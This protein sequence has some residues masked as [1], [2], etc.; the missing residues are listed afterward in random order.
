M[1]FFLLTLPILVFGFAAQANEEQHSHASKY[2]GQEARTI[3]SLSPDDIAELKRGGGW[4][5]AK[6]AELNGVP[7]P[8]HLLELKDK[9]P[10]SDNQVSKIRSIFDGMKARAI[11]QGEHP[12][13]GPSG[14]Y[15]PC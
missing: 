1:K 8:A 13:R 6:A 15:V 9:I 4:G 11:A 2:V 14:K 5:L 10:L 12:A 7:G 3:K